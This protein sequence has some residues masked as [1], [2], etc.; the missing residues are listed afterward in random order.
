MIF[1]RRSADMGGLAV[2]N[3]LFAFR[4]IA[5]RSSP[6]RLFANRVPIELS[7][8]AEC[9]WHLRTRSRGIC[10][11]IDVKP[12][13]GARI[14]R[15]MSQ[16]R[17]PWHSV[18]SSP[19]VRSP[20]SECSSEASGTAS[21]TGSEVSPS[22]GVR[23]AEVSSTGLAAITASASLSRTPSAGMSVSPCNGASAFCFRHELR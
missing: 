8:R 19:T 22:P 1:C 23:S 4:R 20:T 18:P 5:V 16:A 17:P 11:S 15:W 6:L 12:D 13:A 3:S 14:C 7:S 10:G 2:R 21:V 9:R